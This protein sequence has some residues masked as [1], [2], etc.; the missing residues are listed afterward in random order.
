VTAPEPLAVLREFGIADA[1]ISPVTGGHINRSWR[2]LPQNLLLQRLNPA[3]FP[4]GGAVMN[5]LASV[6][7]H[8][9]RSAARLGIQP[10]RGVLRLVP[11]LSG[12]AAV[13]TDDGSWW[14]LVH[15]FDRTRT[16]EQSSSPVIAREAGRAFGRFQLLLADYSGPPLHETIV[17]FH[18]TRRRVE[19]LENAAR[20]DAAGRAGQ[21]RS[22]LG[23]ALAR[24]EVAEVL[25]PLLRS[26]ALPTR[27]VHN[28]AKLSNV[29]FEED[30]DRALVVID[31]D[32]VMPGT[33]LYDTGDLIRSLASPTAE[34]ETDR[35][36]I[37]VSNEVVLALLA[38]F[39]EGSGGTLTETERGLLVFSG[40]LLAYEQSVRFL[41]DY[42]EGDRYYRVARPGQNLD[43]A[44]A[45]FRLVE[46]LEAER[47]WLDQRTRT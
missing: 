26:G 42:L 46:C 36:K 16:L 4:D 23:F 39:E 22:E 8:L 11:A 30:A 25:P 10:E 19:L 41:T 20:I 33:L 31:L 9:E 40:I 45:Q 38:G 5:N 28:D 3:V 47:L 37:R 44:R 13:Q 12:A 32:T 7:A 1:R 34:D 15:F 43:R 35:S 14:R 6:C 21:V 27:V 2:V 24:R 29:L 18:D 17:G